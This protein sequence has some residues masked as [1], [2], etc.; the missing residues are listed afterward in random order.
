[1]YIMYTTKTYRNVTT[2]YYNTTSIWKN[3]GIGADLWHSTFA[4]LSVFFTLIIWMLGAIV[5]P[6]LVRY[7]V[8][9]SLT[10]LSSKVILTILR[11]IIHNQFN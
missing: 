1:M 5:V 3:L 10:S 7:L 8:N 2:I 9:L 4:F 6:L 11:K